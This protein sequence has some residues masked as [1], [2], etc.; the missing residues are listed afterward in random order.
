MN[1]FNRLFSL[2]LP[3]PRAYVQ[4][5]GAQYGLEKMEREIEDTIVNA[6]VKGAIYQDPDLRTAGIHV[7]TSRNVVQLSGFV[8]SRYVIGK[9]LE[10]IRDVH[11]VNAI[12][13][14]MRLK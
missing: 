4:E 11:G 8:E 2:V 12:R 14:D 6:R 1:P 13:N 10:K 7:A 3:D 5:R 9:A